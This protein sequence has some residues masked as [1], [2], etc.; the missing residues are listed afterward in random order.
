MSKRNFTRLTFS[1][2][3]HFLCK[4][5]ING[6]LAK[7]LIDTGASNSCVNYQKQDYYNLKIYGE[8]FDASSASEGKIKAILTE[9]SIFQLGRSFKSNQAF[10]LIDLNHINKTLISQ[11]VSEIDGI[12][13]ADFFMEN[14]AIIDY[15]KKKLFL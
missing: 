4:A 12:L 6:K 15:S 14:K 5:R 9:K 7:L 1:K 11:G 13:G 10:V 2:T 8:P 3:K